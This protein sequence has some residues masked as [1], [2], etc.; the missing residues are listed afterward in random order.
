MFDKADALSLVEFCTS[1]S[2][3]SSCRVTVYSGAN[4][5]TLT[6]VHC[7]SVSA[8]VVS[9]RRFEGRLVSR[10]KSTRSKQRLTRHARKRPSHKNVPSRFLSP[11]FLLLV[12]SSERIGWITRTRT[13][14][15][16]HYF[17]ACAKHGL[18]SC[19]PQSFLRRNK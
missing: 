19:L 16:R 6:G 15:A 8:I 1:W 13:P 10:R 9:N 11:S 7:A 12:P 5:A 2:P 3:H 14:L 18:A 17:G 4:I